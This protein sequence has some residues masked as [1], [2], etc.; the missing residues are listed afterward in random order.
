MSS[1]QGTIA[2]ERMGNGLRRIYERGE[3][4][5]ERWMKV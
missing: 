4:E 5:F 2:D 1:L 3:K